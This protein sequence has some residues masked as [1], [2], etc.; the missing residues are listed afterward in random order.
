MLDQPIPDVTDKDVIR[1]ISR[2]FDDSQLDQVLT[3]LEKYEKE[4]HYDSSPRINLAIL[5]LAS[6]G[7]IKVVEYTKIAIQ[8]YRDV[9]AWA[10]YPRYM[11]EV[12]F[13]LTE[14]EV[15]E[16]IIKDDWRQY[17]EWLTRE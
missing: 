8:D 16:K 2:D 1:I 17:L 7:I 15:V 3:I 10:E 4:E 11:K 6:G 9:L 5:K 13:D 14:Q 12:G